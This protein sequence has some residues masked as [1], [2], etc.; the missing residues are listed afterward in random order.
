M[1]SRSE[2]LAAISVLKKRGDHT[3]WN[4]QLPQAREVFQKITLL[5]WDENI[6]DEEDFIWFRDQLELA[7]TEHYR[8]QLADVE[9]EPAPEPVSSAEP[10]PGLIDTAEA[11]RM[12]ALLGTDRVIACAYGTTNRYTPRRQGDRYDWSKVPTTVDWAAVERDL[13]QNGTKNLG[14]IS[15]PGGTRVI[16]RPGS[17]GEIF[18]CS[19]LVYEIDGLPKDQQWGLWEK[20]G[21]EPTLVMDT[22]NDSLHCWSRLSKPL[23]PQQ[24]KDAR[25]RLSLAIEKHLPEGVK[26]DTAM[27]STHQPARLAG[28]IHPKSGNRSTIVLATGKIHD[29]DEF[30]ALL[31]E[32]PIDTKTTNATGCVW[33][34]DSEDSPEV[35]FSWDAKAHHLQG[36]T[37]PLEVALGE[38]TIEDIEKGIEG[39][40]G[41]RIKRAWSI[42]KTV[43]CAEAQLNELGVP[44]TGTACELF[45]RFVVNSGIDVDYCHGDVD[46]AF[47]RYWESDDI[48]EGDLSRAAL[49]G[50][51]E[52]ID[53]EHRIK[54]PAPG[55]WIW[56]ARQATAKL[57]EV[58]KKAKEKAVSRSYT[59]L[60]EDIFNAAVMSNEDS[61]NEGLGE[62]AIRFRKDERKLLPE[63]LTMLRSKYSKRSYRTGEIDIRKVASLEYALEGFLPKGEVIHLFAP[64]FCGK[65]SL[66]LGMAASLIQGTGF[67]DVDIP[68]EPRSCLFI[69]TDSGASR[70]GIEME[71]QDLLSDPRFVPGPEQ[72]LHIWAPD[73]HQGVEAWVASFR[74]LVKLREEAEKLQIGAIF[75]D[76]VKGM[77]SGTGMDYT[78]N[79]TVNQFVKLLRQSVAQPLG[80]PIVLINHKGMDQREGAGA[81][82]WSESCGQVIELAF[83]YQEKQQLAMVRE[84]TIRKDNLGG[85]RNFHYKMEDGQLQ[86]ALGTEVIKDTS[87]EVL[88]TL[89]TWSLHGT[90]E[91]TRKKIMGEDTPLMHLSRATKDRALEQLCTRGGPLVKVGRGRFRLREDV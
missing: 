31:P 63:L 6:S 13:K 26:T 66:C 78:H 71:K 18:E 79:E 12:L 27:H 75:I 52:A 55:G 1:P 32:L 42:A 34:E 65:T 56:K 51:L 3:T 46:G 82:A 77:M 62:M 60:R 23:T 88:H 11:E 36:V 67:L 81:K 7:E 69:Q 15:C 80:I 16:D 9:D 8:S 24:G 64:W 76:S 54:N 22:G 83:V 87:D 72:M 25:K 49:V 44:F 84:L 30:L 40:D 61:Y 50:R 2:L 17:P 37:V 10:E 4:G 70:F 35:K 89:K 39:G 91:F 74:G 20:V 53:W 59:Q 43:Q 68:S 58:L 41:R 28:G 48:G 21:F 85:P 29:N 38:T 19:L 73:D 33:R 86:I 45:E 57:V 90:K 14:F 5:D 47:D